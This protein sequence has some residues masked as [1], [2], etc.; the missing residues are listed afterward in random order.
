MTKRVAIYTR[1]SRDN[2]GDERSPTRQEADCR[3]FAA[4]R[5]WEVVV[6]YRDVDLSAYAPTVRRP[7]YEALLEAVADREI[8]GVLVWKLDR[9]MRRSAE[10]ER[11]WASCEKAGVSLASVTEPV[12]TSNEMGL[13][14]VRILVTFAGLESST[15]SMRLRSAARAAALAGERHPGPRAYGW[16]D[17]GSTI[18]AEEAAVIREGAARVLRGET[19]CSIARDLN[20]RGLRRRRGGT[21]TGQKLRTILNHP[22]LAGLRSYHGEIV[23][24]GTWPAILDEATSASLRLLFADPTRRFVSDQRTVNLLK[25]FPALWALRRASGRLPACPPLPAQGVH[26]LLTANRLR[27][28]LHQARRSR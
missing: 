19:L 17:A 12:D 3:A 7:A 24:K 1:V 23:A 10:F 14:I 11:F 21:W 25:G 2:L 18:V 15:R 22:S 26:L 4:I 5:D 9:L 27:G 8:D 13:A 6:A 16:D 20:A 28:H